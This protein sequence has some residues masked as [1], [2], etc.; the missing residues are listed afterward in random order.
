[1]RKR[2]T[3][4]T[5]SAVTAFIMMLSLTLTGCGGNESD[6]DPLEGVETQMVLDDSGRDEV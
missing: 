6:Y 2:K 4:I 5:V 1:M 3:R